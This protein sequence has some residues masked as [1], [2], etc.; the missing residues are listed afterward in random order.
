MEDRQIPQFYLLNHN[1]YAYR[2]AITYSASTWEHDH[3][4]PDSFEDFVGL[5]DMELQA[6]IQ[7]TQQ[8]DLVVALWATSEEIKEKFL[9]NMT[10]ELL[11]FVNEELK[12]R[13]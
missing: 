6:V 7:Q 8:K 11:A 4:R 9:W 2:F 12:T 1:H 13:E 5:A 3:G 10:G